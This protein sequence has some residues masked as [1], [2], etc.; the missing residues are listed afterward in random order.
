MAKHGKKDTTQ[1]TS[2]F[3]LKLFLHQIIHPQNISITKD[4]GFGENI[5]GLGEFN[6]AMRGPSTFLLG[7]DKLVGPVRTSFA[8]QEHTSA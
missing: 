6:I 4:I 3:N 5:F 2:V 7:L 1:V 8:D